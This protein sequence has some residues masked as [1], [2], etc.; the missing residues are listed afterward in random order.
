MSI[1]QLPE[2]FVFYEDDVPIALPI[3]WYQDDTKLFCQA[4]ENRTNSLIKICFAIY[5]EGNRIR[6]FIFLN[7]NQPLTPVGAYFLLKKEKAWHKNIAKRYSILFKFAE[8]QKYNVVVVDDIQN[9][10]QFKRKNHFLLWSTSENKYQAAFLLDQYVCAETIKKI[11]KVLIHLYKGDKACLGA[12]HYL[13][14][15]GFFNTK[16][17]EPPYVVLEHEGNNVLSTEQILQYYEEKLKPKEYK[18]KEFKSTKIITNIDLDKKKKDWWYFYN[19]KQNKSDA[20][21]S[22]ALYLMHFNLTDEEIKKILINES[23]D[24]QNR[25]IG[26]LDDYLDRTVKKARDFFKPFKSDEE[27]RL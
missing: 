5:G 13:R 10:E 2:N 21:F 7:N 25:K 12:S 3:D 16:Y 17:S 11:Q 26:H 1:D 23:D 18:P 19:I 24:I 14:M 6:K 27:N 8:N 9:I 22:Y 15:P 4:I 20:D